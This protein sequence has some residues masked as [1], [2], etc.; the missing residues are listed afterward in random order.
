M[1]KQRKVVITTTYNEMGIIIDTKAEEVAQPEVAK[2]TN[3]LCNDCISRQ[4]A[5]TQL[6]HNK[7]KGDDE[8]ELAVQ[9][10]IQTI[11]KLPAAQPEPPWI[12]ITE[13]LPEEPGVYTV[14]N[15]DYEVVR[16]TFSGSD[17]SRE[18]WER[19]VKAWLPL[20]KPY[21]ED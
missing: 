15:N 1:N 16:Y 13:R 10:D 21:V 19:C 12:P 11:W 20:P 17:T 2:D 8:W 7:N 4:V 18:Y 14:T 6:S 9:N 3:V 5:I